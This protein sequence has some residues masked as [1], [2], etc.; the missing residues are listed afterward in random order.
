MVQ[1]PWPHRPEAIGA[2]QRGGSEGLCAWQLELVARFL[3]F[4]GVVGWV[5]FMGFHMG[6]YGIR[7][8]T[9]GMTIIYM[10]MLYILNYIYMIYDDKPSWN[11]SMIS[12]IWSPALCYKLNDSDTIRG[13]TSINN[14]FFMRTSR[15]SS[16]VLFHRQISKGFVF[17]QELGGCPTK[18]KGGLSDSRS[19]KKNGIICPGTFFRVTLSHYMIYMHQCSVLE[20]VLDDHSPQPAWLSL[21]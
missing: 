8:D 2:L 21:A 16:M 20:W 3:F 10:N 6:E 1:Q 13:D 4:F 11:Q 18:I 7:V 19:K 17:P 12:P 5:I 9:F 14:S 15:D